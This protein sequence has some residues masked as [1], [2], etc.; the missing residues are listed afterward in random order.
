MLKADFH[1]HSKEDKHDIAIKYGARGLI[2]HAAKLGFK[3][4]AI[5]HHQN[6]FYPKSLK[7]YA[8][9]KGILLL[10]GGE[11]MVE[12]REVLV[13]GKENVKP[14]LTFA[15]L[16]KLHDNGAL[17]IAP[18]PFYPKKSC[19]HEQLA[20]HIDCFDGIE[21][22]HFYTGGFTNL[23][24][25]QALKVA[26]QFSKPM[27][28]TSDCHQLYQMGTTFTLVDAKPTISSVIEAVKQGR[29]KLSTKPI[30]YTYMARHISYFSVVASV[31]LAKSLKIRQA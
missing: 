4:L 27:I 8:K 20:K 1:M 17:V 14:H 26:E 5:T 11:M 30:S 9:Q 16:E 23:Y 21:F 7:D 10:P 18:H 3:V 2:D 12:G 25:K 22:S 15:E 29:V 31:K 6:I 19:L 13:I 24:N 28:G